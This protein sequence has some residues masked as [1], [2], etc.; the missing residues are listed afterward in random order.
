MENRDELLQHY[1]TT[2]TELQ[3]AIDGLTASQMT[4]PSIDGWSVKDHL[5]HLATWDEVRA[6][7]VERISRG[8][9]SAW[10]MT[11]EQDEAYRSSV[12]PPGVPSLSVEAASTF[13]W[14]RWADASVG[15]DRFG[16]SAPGDVVMDELGINP[17][18]VVAHAKALLGWSVFPSGDRPSR[19]ARRPAER[20]H[21]RPD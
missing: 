2:R 10:L 15:I 19:P 4:E 20:N 3:A 5:L 7:E 18:N 6:T 9:Q 21:R 17:T 11:E 16:A 12:L 8:F 1:Q 14:S 13:G